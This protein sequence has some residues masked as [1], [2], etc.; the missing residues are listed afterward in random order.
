[1]DRCPKAQSTSGQKS[2]QSTIYCWTDQY[3]WR[4]L[5]LDPKHNHPGDKYLNCSHHGTRVPQVQSTTGQ[6]NALSR[7]HTQLDPPPPPPP[8][9]QKK[10]HGKDGGGGG[11]GLPGI[12]GPPVAGPGWGAAGRRSWAAAWLHPGLL[13]A[14]AA[15]WCGLPNPPPLPGPLTPQLKYTTKQSGPFNPWTSYRN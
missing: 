11:Y 14:E 7:P 10:Q 9:T 15:L 12:L 8:P 13:A 5:P 2:A 4:D 3:L 6:R 1:M